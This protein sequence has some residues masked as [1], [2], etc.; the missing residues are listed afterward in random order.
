MQER[1]AINEKKQAEK[2]LKKAERAAKAEQ[3][4]K[5]RAERE[6]SAL[7]KTLRSAY[8]STLKNT[9]EAKDKKR[10]P[11]LIVAGSVATTMLF[12]VI[13]ASFMQISQIQTEMKQMEAT[14]RALKEDERKLGMELEGRYSSK[15][16]SLAADMGLTGAY[17][18]PTYLGDEESLPTEEVVE[19]E[20]KEQKEKVNSLM[21]AFSQ[22]FKKFLEFID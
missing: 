3:R 13:V 20:T 21:S 11:V 9:V 6:P 1:R 19:E 14:I 10:F 12:M 22:S 18:Q 4:R 5:E 15:I 7:V 2:D 16:E 8:S 17:R